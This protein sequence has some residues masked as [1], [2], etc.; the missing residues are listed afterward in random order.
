M[1]CSRSSEWY[2]SVHEIEIEKCNLSNVLLLD[3]EASGVFGGLSLMVIGVCIWVVHKNTRI[4][5]RWARTTGTLEQSIKL[6][7]PVLL[8]FAA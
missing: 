8:V 5:R 2:V 4:C 1:A 3:L 6:A 7:L